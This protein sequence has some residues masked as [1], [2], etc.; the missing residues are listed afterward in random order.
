MV[1]GEVAAEVFGVA[2][3]AAVEIFA[4]QGAAKY[5]KPL[6]RLP[7]ERNALRAFNDFSAEYSDHPGT[8]KLIGRTFVS[9]RHRTVWI[10]V[11]RAQK[12]VKLIVLTLFR[13]AERK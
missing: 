11:V 3:E 13:A 9:V 8:T 12:A 1:P 6:A 2:A 7:R 5:G 10:K 4:E